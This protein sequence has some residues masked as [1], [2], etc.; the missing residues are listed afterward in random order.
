MAR[1]K[2]G[3]RR[4]RPRL[5]HARSRE[6][7]RAGRRGEIDRGSE[8]LREKNRQATSRDDVEM[9]PA[10]ILFG[11]GHLDRYQYDALAF[12]TLLLHQ[13]AKA[14]GGKLSVGNLWTAIVW[15]ATKTAPAGTVLAIG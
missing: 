11:R 8:L 3:R 5:K 10:G 6:T 9:T 14:M 7:T 1:R 4:G 13:V 2:T 15:A 12:V